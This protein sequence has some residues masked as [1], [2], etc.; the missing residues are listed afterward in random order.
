MFRD[1]DYVITITGKFSR[2]VDNHV[3]NG[4]VVNV[5]RHCHY[6][7]CRARCPQMTIEVVIAPVD[8]QKAEAVKPPY[9]SQIRVAR[10]RQPSVADSCTNNAIA[11]R[12][13]SSHIECR[14]W[15]SVQLRPLNGRI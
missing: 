4:R 9:V 8:V 14:S 15:C 7:P 3:E 5:A 13:E 6:R 10:S 1:N 11:M 2:L 12:D